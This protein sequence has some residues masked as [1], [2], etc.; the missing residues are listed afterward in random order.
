M[1]ED[2]KDARPDWFF[3]ALHFSRSHH[4]GPEYTFRFI[5]KHVNYLNL[6]TWT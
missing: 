6:G 4:A 5:C 1:T 2:F 3:F